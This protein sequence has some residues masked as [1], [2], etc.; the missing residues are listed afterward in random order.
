MSPAHRK[1]PIHNP[2]NE[3]RI[4]NHQNIQN[5]QDPE[6]FSSTNH[7]K[8]ESRWTRWRRGRR[9]EATTDAK[10][11]PAEET[12]AKLQDRQDNQVPARVSSVCVWLKK[13]YKT[14]SLTD[15]KN[16]VTDKYWKTLRSTL[17]TWQ[18]QRY[19]EAWRRTE[20][21]L[22]IRKLSPFCLPERNPAP[23]HDS[24][25]KSL[26]N[27]NLPLNSWWM[28]AQSFTF[29]VSSLSTG[30]GNEEKPGTSK[31]KASDSCFY[32]VKGRDRVPPSLLPLF[33]FSF[34]LINRWNVNAVLWWEDF[35]QINL[36]R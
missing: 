22:M 19:G 29:S 18:L 30:S 33:T 25:N 1:I 15:F 36:Q 13:K 12:R 3:A 6:K 9:W 28:A 4:P 11:K 32:F 24:I 23:D 26:Q 8:A 21:L 27:P 34:Q 35:L 16:Y 31:G 5:H 10:P 14:R 17:L 2:P 7:K 20:G